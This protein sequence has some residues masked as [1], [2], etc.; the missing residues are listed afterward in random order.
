MAKG[1]AKSFETFGHFRLEP[2]PRAIF[3]LTLGKYLAELCQEAICRLFSPFA[4]S[5]LADFWQRGKTLRLLARG[6]TLGKWSDSASELR[7]IG[8]IIITG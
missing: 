6:E 8:L 2:L 1:F 3:E 7:R 4:K 5:L